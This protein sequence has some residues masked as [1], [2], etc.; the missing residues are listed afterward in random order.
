MGNKGVPGSRTETMP[1]SSRTARDYVA[2]IPECR[3][4]VVEG[5]TFEDLGRT[6]NAMVVIKENL[7]D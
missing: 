3:I 5:Y 2:L 7:E 6:P 4:L 1:C